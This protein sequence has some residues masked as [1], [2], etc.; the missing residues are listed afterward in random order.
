M[1]SLADKKKRARKIFNILKKTYPDCKCALHHKNAFELLIATILS[2]QC[3]D[4]RVNIVTVDLFK[5]YRTPADFAKLRPATLEKEIK[6]TGFY[7]NKTKSILGASKAICENFGGVVPQTM[8]ELLTLPGV[9]RKTA[10]VVLG[11]AFGKATGMV[12]DT[13]VFRLS[14]RMG[15]SD[16]TKYPEKMEKDLME[17]FP[18]SR[19]IMAGHL[20][21]WHG[22][23]ICSA[24][25]P[26]H[27]ECPVEAICPKREKK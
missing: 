2:A 21:I 25:K 1:E 18:T 27:D 13:H 9:A 12:V 6:S 10:N 15:L 17:V 4:E 14:Y 8:D 24:R 16:E 19:W 26:M 11:T 3:T 5:K 23:R 20:L 7:R 22:R